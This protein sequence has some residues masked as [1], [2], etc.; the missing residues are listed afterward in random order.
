M[1]TLAELG[2]KCLWIRL[3]KYWQ[4]S[5]I[6]FHLRDCSLL[7]YP[8]TCF[9]YMTSSNFIV[10]AAGCWNSSGFFLC[11]FVFNSECRGEKSIPFT[12]TESIYNSPRRQFECRFFSYCQ[13]VICRWMFFHCGFEH[14]Q[15]LHCTPVLSFAKVNLRGD[16]GV[17]SK[18]LASALH[19]TWLF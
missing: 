15:K 10:F 7:C 13:R 4:Y 11:F 18:Q 14:S 2:E 1:C 17:N 12:S 3:V 5:A 19:G 6:V 8:L 9:F 16:I